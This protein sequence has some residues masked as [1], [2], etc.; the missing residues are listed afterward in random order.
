MIEGSLY[1]LLDDQGGVVNQLGAWLFKRDSAECSD[2][3][4]ARLERFQPSW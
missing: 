1:I 2:L 3:F 4:I